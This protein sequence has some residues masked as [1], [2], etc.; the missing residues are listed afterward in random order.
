MKKIKKWFAYWSDNLWKSYIKD[1]QG[2]ILI[3][4]VFFFSIWM[5]IEIPST[6][7]VGAPSWATL[8]WCLFT[9]CFIFTGILY[10]KIKKLKKE[11]EKLTERIE[12]LKEEK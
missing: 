4:G 2:F 10:S 6:G 12:K 7:I 9:Y 3:A 11:N 1:P 8:I 5:W